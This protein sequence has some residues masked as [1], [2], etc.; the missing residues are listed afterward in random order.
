MNR[1]DVGRSFFALSI[2]VFGLQY[3][4]FGHLAGGL[5]PLPPWTPDAGPVVAYLAG[6][7]LLAAGLGMLLS[8]HGRLSALIVGAFFLFC[9]LFLHLL[10]ASA[11]WN[12]G[13][14]RTRALEPLVLSGAAFVLARALPAASPGWINPLA[15]RLAF[16][17]RLLFAI[18]M[19]PFGWQHFMYAPF[20]ATLI[21]SWIPGHMFFTYFTGLAFIA[22]AIAIVARIQAPLAATLLGIMFFLW[23]VVLHA[24]RVAAAV[25]N[26]DEWTSLFVA[27]AFSGASFIVASTM[28]K[29]GRRIA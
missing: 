4:L 24:P 23:V 26:G 17:G 9:V 5:P 29:S 3:L 14:D 6:I 1:F 8:R 10:H 7:L 19:I 12:N 27:L 15:E 22:A 28:E 21:P 16:C 13:V 25:H 11:V 2:A 18:P 20:I